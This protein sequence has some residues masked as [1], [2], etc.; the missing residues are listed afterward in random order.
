MHCI[1]SFIGGIFAI[2][3]LLEHNNVFGSAETSNMIRLVNDLLEMD[4]SNTLMRIGNLIFYAAGITTA[5]WMAKYHPSI[6]KMV[7]LAV[8]AIAAFVLIL[9]P[10]DVNPLTALYPI[11]F[12]MSIQWCTFRGVGKNPSATTFSTGNFRQLVTHTFNYLTEKNS[13]SLSNVK[14]YLSTMFSFHAG[15]AVVCILKPY[16]LHHSIAIVYIPL[17]A[18]AVCEYVFNFRKNTVISKIPQNAGSDEV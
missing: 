6:Q 18:A 12:A 9:T 4:L 10:A 16:I 17:L 1:M 14:F 15:V 2:Y 5:L 11:A 8:D 13:E 7:C 3:A